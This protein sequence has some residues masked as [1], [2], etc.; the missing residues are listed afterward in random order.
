MYNI[1]ELLGRDLFLYGRGYNTRL[2]NYVNHEFIKPYYYHYFDVRDDYYTREH[3][4]VCIKNNGEEIYEYTCECDSYKHTGKCKHIAASLL[5]YYY[6]I[7][8]YQYIDELLIGNKI[9]S[10]FKNKNIK[11]KKGI[12]RKVNIDVELVFD[13]YMPA[14][15]I[16]IGLD[17]MYVITDNKLNSFIRA[18]KNNSIMEFGKGFTYDANVHYFDEFG[19]R[20]INFLLGS[21]NIN[22]NAYM[23]SKREFNNLLDI[24]NDRQIKIKGHGIINS[25][26][27]G[28]PTSYHLSKKENYILSIDDFDSYS[29]LTTD[30]VFILYNRDLYILSEKEANIIMIYLRN[31]INEINFSDDNIDLFKNGLFNE[32]KKNIVIDDNIDTIK[33]PSKPEVN[34]YFDISSILKCKVEFD[35]NGTIVNYFDKEEEFRSQDDEM[36]VI[37]DLVS[38]KFTEK[39]KYFVLEENDDI[40]DFIENNLSKLN[41]KYHVFLDKKLKETKFIKKLN[42]KNNFSIGQDNILSYNFNI[43]EIDKKEVNNLIKALR[44]KKKYYRLKNNE[45]VNLLDNDLQNLSNIMEGLDIKKEI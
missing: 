5:N 27:Y 39:G 41:D 29:I 25:I 23:L 43:D 6:Q 26:K 40:Y 11:I 36:E 1:F 30:C 15:R 13:N 34:L 37:S 14:F 20:I 16:L 9:L 7:A 32:I 42:I 3:Y 19:E 44:L 22:G 24:L 2:I 10:N 21:S 8:N 28:M 17:K 31:R 33:L 35:Y 12:K 4:K 38:N 18:Y 45:I